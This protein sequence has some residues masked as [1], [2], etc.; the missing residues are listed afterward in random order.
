MDNLHVQKV[1]EGDTAKFSYF[2]ENY[3]D[4]PAFQFI[5]DVPVDWDT[6]IVLNGEIGEYITIVRKDRMSNDWYLGSIT[7]SE[8]RSFEIDL[9]FLNRDANFRIKADAPQQSGNGNTCSARTIDY[10]I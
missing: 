6:T 10:N 3:K 2:I 8:A 4:Q 9:S 5:K 7:N 1:I